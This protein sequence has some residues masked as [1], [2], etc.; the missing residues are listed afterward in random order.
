[1]EDIFQRY[2]GRGAEPAAVD[3]WSDFMV[4]RKSE[5]DFHVAVLTSDEYRTLVGGADEQY[6]ESLYLDILHRPA[7]PTG[8][9]DWLEI[10][11]RT[12]GAAEVVTGLLNAPESYTKVSDAAYTR[13]F[14][15][16]LAESDGIVTATSIGSWLSTELSGMSAGQSVFDAVANNL[17]NTSTSAFK[18]FR[19]E[20]I[21][22]LQESLDG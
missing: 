18:E 16:L 20:F 17:A 10:L 8:E 21:D 15:Q 1:V 2:L 22:H 19:E 3:Y 4:Q 6:V 9:A 13:Y 12:N 11:G 7:D 5:T 14:G